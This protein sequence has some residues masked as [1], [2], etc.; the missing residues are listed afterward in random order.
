[1]WIDGNGVNVF[2]LVCLTERPRFKNPTT[3]YR[4]IGDVRAATAQMKNSISET[5]RLNLSNKRHAYFCTGA[6]SGLGS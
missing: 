1:M 3:E 4:D 6:T 5:F 2:I